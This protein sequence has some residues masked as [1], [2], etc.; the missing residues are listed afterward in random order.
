MKQSRVY[1]EDETIIPNY[2]IETHRETV[3]ERE[4]GE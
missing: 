4:K 3:R 2:E 1:Y